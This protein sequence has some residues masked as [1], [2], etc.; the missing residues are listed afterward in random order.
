M[1]V[2]YGS[3]LD[4]TL[5]GTLSND[6]I[7]GLDGADIFHWTSGIGNDT[8]HGGDYA[9]RYDANQYTP[10]NPGGD[11]LLIDGNIG[12][13][14]FFATTEA[15]SVQV[16]NNTLKFTG[17]E[18]FSGTE[19]NDIIRGGAANLNAAHNGTPPHGLS[20]YTRGGNDDIIG[21]RFDDIID[22]GAGNDTIRGGDGHDFILSSTGNDLIYG[23][24]GGENIR[25]GTGDRSHNPGHDTI[26]GGSGNDL[27]NLWIKDGDVYPSNEAVGIRG[28]EVKLTKVGAD[29]SFAGHAET[30]IGGS[31]SVKFAQFEL[32]WTHAGNDTI[33]GSGATIASNG[34]GFNFNTRW[35]HDVMIGS[36]GND[37]LVA[38]EGKDT[39]TGGAGNDQLWIGS[40][41][42]GDGNRDVLNFARGHGQ[43]TVYGFDT[44]LDV[45]NLGGRNYSAAENS[46]GTLLN[47]GG[48][49]TILLAHVFDF[50]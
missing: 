34:A 24:A 10:F 46:Q 41:E 11:R 3:N 22:G 37:T 43:D 44:H 30:T 17:I 14:V 28:V 29:S 25:W 49:D 8:I 50:I 35:G 2:I 4:N 48:G 42:S 19:G 32:G 7:W 47:L 36:R 12:A 27:I 26:Y 15:G 39:V 9:D 38:D 20:I 5:Q 13:K 16:G 1:A 6:E 21:S 40:G 31:A 33:D 18:R 23:G 45:L